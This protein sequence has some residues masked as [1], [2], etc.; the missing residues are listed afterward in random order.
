MT[1]II[2]YLLF[3]SAGFLEDFFSFRSLPCIEYYSQITNGKK[4]VKD[5]RYGKV[6]SID[7]AFIKQI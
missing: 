5:K 1:E 4:A 7:K 2:I 3:A 6:L